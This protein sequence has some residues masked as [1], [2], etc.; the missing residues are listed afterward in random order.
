[1]CAL[2]PIE[3]V[4]CDGP[5]IKVIGVGGGAGNALNWMI[6]KPLHKHI[7][8][9]AVNTDSQALEKSLA[10]QKIQIGARLTGGRGAAAKPE[11][12]RQAA[13]E[14][15]ER[16]QAAIGKA[17]M[18]IIVAGMGGG[19]GTGAAPVIARIAQ[20][21]GAF[22][23]PV[24]THPFFFEGKVRQSTAQEGIEKLLALN[25][26]LIVIHCDRTLPPLR[27]KCAY[28]DWGI[29]LRVDQSLC[30]AV[31]ALTDP[32]LRVGPIGYDFADHKTILSIPGIAAMGMGKA[33]GPSRA[34]EAA[35]LALERS[36]LGDHDIATAQGVFILI[37]AETQ[38]SV[39]AIAEAANSVHER[40]SAEANFAFTCFED[41]SLEDA[42]QVIVLATGLRVS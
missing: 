4:P 16:I 34:K 19:T 39:D 2:L 24:V 28:S 26:S 8:F 11:V 18:V 41:E 40:A 25:L 9:I 35:T 22:T 14:D 32:I 42:M 30:T 31:Q 6:E 13:L 29:L 3:I 38:Y 37:I 33:S 36:F 15:C 27:K 21:L 5:I 7:E 20:E 12:G 1:M 23:V 17:D 10:P